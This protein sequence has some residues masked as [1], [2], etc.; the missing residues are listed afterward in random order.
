MVADDLVAWNY[1]GRKSAA[2]KDDEVGVTGK[3]M[4]C[5]E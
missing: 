1:Q 2:H 3:W 4:G 5:Y